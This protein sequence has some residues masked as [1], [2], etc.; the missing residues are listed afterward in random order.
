MYFDLILV[1]GGFNVSWFNPRGVD[2]LV[3]E[4]TIGGDQPVVLTIPT[5]KDDWLD[6]VKRIRQ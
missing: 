5:E 1:P 4:T 2:P 6:V 3:S